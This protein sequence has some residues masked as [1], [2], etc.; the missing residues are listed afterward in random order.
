MTQR[1]EKQEDVRF[2]N[3]PIRLAGTLI[4]P[5]RGGRHPA[6]VLVHGSGPQ[7]RWWMVPFA[8]FLVRHG[9]ALLGYDKRGTGE[10][11]GDWNAA[12][13]DAL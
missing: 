10:S 12:S 6:I 1:I 4:S 7:T 3:G 13:F 2:A 11:T 9:I 8:R 5:N